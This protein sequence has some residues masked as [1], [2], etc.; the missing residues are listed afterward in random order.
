[1]SAIPSQE[2]QQ[3]NPVPQLIK[4]SHQW[5]VNGRVGQPPIKI[6]LNDNM[7]K[8]DGWLRQQQRQSDKK[9]LAPKTCAKFD[10]QEK[11][12]VFDMIFAL[13]AEGVPT[14]VS[15]QHAR[16]WGR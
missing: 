3:T 9:R 5:V 12:N 1:M 4:D 14:T 15:L 10:D 2:D 7:M 6:F 11:C 8:S 13:K 16:A